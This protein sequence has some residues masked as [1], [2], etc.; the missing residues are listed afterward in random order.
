ME[1]KSVTNPLGTITIQWLEVPP[2]IEMLARQGLIRSGLEGP[3]A[4]RG[5]PLP[6]DARAFT[7]EQRLISIVPTPGSPLLPATPHA[8]G[9][10]PLGFAATKRGRCQRGHVGRGKSKACTSN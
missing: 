9:P 4:G 1:A 2:D 3:V 10:P 6:A 8:S 5:L 7:L